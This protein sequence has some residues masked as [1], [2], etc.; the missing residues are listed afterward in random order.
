MVSFA[1][2]GVG[3]GSAC[4]CVEVEVEVEVEVDTGMGI[5]VGVA[6]SGFS[7]PSISISSLNGGTTLTGPVGPGREGGRGNTTCFVFGIFPKCL[8][9]FFR[10]DS[11]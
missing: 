7:T 8:F 10:I 2:V 9:S 1:A 5:G 11:G 6:S 3:V 4:A